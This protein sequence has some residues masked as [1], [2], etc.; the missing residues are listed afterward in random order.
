MKRYIYA[1]SKVDFI[2]GKQVENLNYPTIFMTPFHISLKEIYPKR[3]DA[4]TDRRTD[5][6]PQKA[7]L[8]VVYR[9]LSTAL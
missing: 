5:T 2:V 6:P 1:F 7:L 9:V 4:F 3:T 8:L